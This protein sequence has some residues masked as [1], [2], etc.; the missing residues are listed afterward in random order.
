MALLGSK[1]RRVL[2]IIIRTGLI[3]MMFFIGL[4][5]MFFMGLIS[6]AQAQTSAN[7]SGVDERLRPRSSVPELKAPFDLPALQEEGPSKGSDSQKFEINGVLFEGSEVLPD[8][9]LQEI[10][11]PYIDRQITLSDVYDLATS[12]TALYRNAGYILTQAIVPAQKISDGVLR[13]RI[14]EGFIEK[15]SIEGDV[16]GALRF[17]QEQAQRIVDSRPLTVEVL[18][19]ELL[20]AGDLAGLTVRSVL[21]PSK[22]TLG[23]TDLTLVV[24]EDT[25]EGYAAIDN[26]GS[27]YLGREE[28]VAAGFGNDLF[29]LAGQAGVTAVVTPNEGPELA[30]GALSYEVPLTSSGLSLFTSYS[31]SRTRPGLELADL[32]TK[33]MAQAV[34][35]ELSY[36]FTRSRDLNLIG[37]L[38]LYGANI[39]SENSVIQP[40]F[41]DKV[42]NMFAR[43]YVNGLDSL[44]A[45][46][47]ARFTFYQSLPFLGSF[48]N[49]D[50]DL[51]RT[52]VDNDYRSFNFEL[53]R[54]Q[55]LGGNF[56]LLM[57]AAGQTSFNDD[58]L[59]SEEWG[60]GGSFYGRAFDPSEISGDKGI[61][62]MAE[63]Q[64]N[65][66]Y[67]PSWSS[68]TQLYSFFETGAVSQVTVLPGEQKTEKLMSFGIGVRTVIQDRVNVD[69]FVAKPYK[70]EVVAEGS[71]SPRLFFSVS[72]SF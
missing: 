53:S 50:T 43:I 61:A 57:G 22:T 60:I 71:R 27:R 13:L 24:E 68:N 32:D 59:A 2:G 66:P 63:L 29:G 15:V 23:A 10:A 1:G 30:Y 36:P 14:V 8:S 7:P 48:D 11:R 16:G 4:T 51:S 17:L 34:R 49:N 6:L 62:A 3:F 40:V 67:Q 21:T 58:L 46:N 72:T 20:I 47:T 37:T 70:R 64:W 18:E 56:A 39:S 44:G 33:G 54:W 5:L 9:Q 25:F 12:V 19:R 35:L 65:S 45:S 31:Y 69:L 28:I 55:P 42:R 52:N 26:Y 41:Y 38:G